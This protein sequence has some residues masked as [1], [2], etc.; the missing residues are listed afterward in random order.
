MVLMNLA[1]MSRSTLLR[2]QRSLSTSALQSLSGKDFLSTAQ[3]SYV[4][5]GSAES[6]SEPTH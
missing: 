1:R 6:E 5:S 3:L 2:S 4:L